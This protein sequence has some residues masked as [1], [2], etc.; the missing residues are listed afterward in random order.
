M[1]DMQCDSVDVIK[2]FAERCATEKA[3]HQKGSTVDGI[4]EL[5]GLPR[6]LIFKTV[7]LELAEV[8]YKAHTGRGERKETLGLVVSEAVDYAS[9]FTR[10]DNF[11]PVW[12]RRRKSTLLSFMREY[13]NG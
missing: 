11:G 5:S 9:Q 10:E 1:S 8:A 6:W 7:A 4:A 2:K 12:Q 3:L 13:L